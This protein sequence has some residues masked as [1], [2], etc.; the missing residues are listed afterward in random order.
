[1]KEWRKRQ[2]ELF[3]WLFETLDELE[4]EREENNAGISTKEE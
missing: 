3:R 4:R 2:K 1:M